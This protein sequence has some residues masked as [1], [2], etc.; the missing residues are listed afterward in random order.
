M[1][2]ATLPRGAR[3][4]H[5]QLLGVDEVQ[6]LGH[7]DEDLVVHPRWHTLRHPTLIMIPT[8]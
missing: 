7:S 3:T 5:G 2:V 8:R 6:R 4:L 1:R